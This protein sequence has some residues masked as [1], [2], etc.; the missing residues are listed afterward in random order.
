[1]AEKPGGRM[2]LNVSNWFKRVERIKEGQL[3]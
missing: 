2:N 3:P 1:M